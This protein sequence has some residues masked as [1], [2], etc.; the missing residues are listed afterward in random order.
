MSATLFD[1]HTSMAFGAKIQ[2]PNGS[3]TVKVSISG[4]VDNTD[5]CVNEWHPQQDGRLP[6]LMEKVQS[7]AQLWNDLLY[8]SGGK[9][10]ITKCSYHP[11]R[12]KFAPDGTPSV[13][14]T[15]PPAIK[16]IDSMTNTAFQVTPLSPYSPHKTLGHWKAPTGSSSTQLSVLRTKMKMISIRISTSWLSRYG[17]RLA[18]HAIYVATLRYVLPQCHFPAKTLRKAEKQSLPSLY[19]KCGFSRKTAQALLFAPLEYGG[20]GFVHWDTIQGEGQ[21]LHFIK[22]WRTDTV[23]SSTLHINVAWCQWQAGISQSILTYY[24]EPIEYLEARWIPSFRKAL[25]RFGATIETDNSFIPQP[26][27]HDDMYIMEV[28]TKSQQF[29]EKDL[30]II[31]YCRLYLHITTISEMFDA[32][33]NLIMEHIRKCN[34]APWFDPAINVSI[35]RRPSEHQIRTRWRSMC[36]VASTSPPPCGSWILPLRIQR[37]TYCLAGLDTSIIRHWYAGSYW[38]CSPARVVDNKFWLT[39]IRP[40]DW[41]PTYTTDVPVHIL[42]RVHMTIYTQITSQSYQIPPVPKRTS[43]QSTF[44]DHILTLD[45]WAQSLLSSI[46]WLHGIEIVTEVLSHMPS[47]IPLLVV[48]DRSSIEGQ[49]MSFGQSD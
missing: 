22:H 15:L 14:T 17:A 35:Q 37:K 44:S 33:G 34:R 38:E 18:Y 28:A 43:A 7:D 5:T 6:R 45:P 40:T 47:E 49:H 27:R 10:E 9:L 23:I 29:T 19:A 16:I 32:D 30:H 21:I 39:L 2:D 41:T 13:E 20:G 8:V 48:S 4:F 31:N 11:L 12:F 42:T 25:H 46:N 1:V 36:A 24:T 3:V 26:E